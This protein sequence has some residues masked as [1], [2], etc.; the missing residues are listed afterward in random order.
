[1]ATQS[2]ASVASLVNTSSSKSGEIYV[3]RVRDV[4]AA[5]T[6]RQVSAAEHLDKLSS[7]REAAAQQADVSRQAFEKVVSELQNYVQRSQRN[8]DFHVDDQTG[9]VV[10]K[11][12]D[13]TND[14]VIR[15]I[16]SEEMLAVARRIQDFLDE[17]QVPVKGMLLEL[18]A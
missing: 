17:Q 16:P 4:E 1:M 7:A 3:T 15:Q 10:V 18:K 9:R 11:V 5:G 2:I 14:E 13:A 12:V 6:E 8:L